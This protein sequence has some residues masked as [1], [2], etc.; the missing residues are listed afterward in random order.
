MYAL[1]LRGVKLSL[2]IC[3]LYFKLALFSCFA[4]DTLFTYSQL[5]GYSVLRWC[6]Y[7]L[8]HI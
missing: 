4:F 8:L 2:G 3:I 5:Y 6:K 7:F 1:R